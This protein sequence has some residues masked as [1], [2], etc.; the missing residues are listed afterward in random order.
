MYNF[1]RRTYV[2]DSIKVQIAYAIAVLM[3]KPRTSGHQHVA[4]APAHCI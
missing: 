3:S 4:N 1:I 2:L